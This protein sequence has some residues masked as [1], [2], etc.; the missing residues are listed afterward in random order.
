MALL[1]CMRVAIMTAGP[2]GDAAPFTGLGHALAREGHDVTLVTHERFA[3]LLAGS[4]GA[5]HA[6]PVDPRV[7]LEPARGRGLHRS[8]TGVGKLVRVVGM[9][10]AVAGRMTDALPEAGEGAD[11]LLLAA[12]LAPLRH[13]VAEG[14][15][16]PSLRLQLHRGPPPGSSHRLCS[17]PAPGA[18]CAGRGCAG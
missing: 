12:A 3:P 14:L 4:G 6:L 18:R 10:R 16:R 9:A 7:E 15:G 5:F 2:R 13:A 8:V 11:V 1:R 17:P